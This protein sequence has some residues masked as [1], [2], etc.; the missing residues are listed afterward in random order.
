MTLHAYYRLRD[1]DAEVK[2]I[3]FDALPTLEELRARKSS[4]T[5][6]TYTSEAA[7]MRTHFRDYVLQTIFRVAQEELGDTLKAADVLVEHA[8]YELDPAPST[9]VISIVADISA[10]QFGIVH[11]AV[12]KAIAKEAKFWSK[13]EQ[14]DYSERIHYSVIPLRI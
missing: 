12:S 2:D 13:S 3:P 14:E 1:L 4:P 6:L 7:K 11:K 5:C 8:H 9:L 10:E